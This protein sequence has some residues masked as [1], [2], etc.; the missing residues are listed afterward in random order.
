MKFI[1]SIALMGLSTA[2]VADSVDWDDKIKNCMDVS[3]GNFITVAQNPTIIEQ[4]KGVQPT[5]VQAVFGDDSLDIPA[6]E[7]LV[8]RAELTHFKEGVSEDGTKLNLRTLLAID[9]NVKGEKRHRMY[10]AI[11]VIE[12]G[13]GYNCYPE[14]AGD[15]SVDMRN[16]VRPSE[17]VLETKK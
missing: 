12:A 8:E 11:Y 5:L 10:N 13:E 4:L 17:V 2:A 6:T 3:I 14:Y 9:V 15:A 16:Y 7:L 1:M